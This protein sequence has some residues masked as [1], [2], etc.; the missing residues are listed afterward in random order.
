MVYNRGQRA[1]F[2]NWAQRGNRGWGYVD[3]LPYFKRS[4]RRIG[5]DDDAVPWP[6]GRIPVTDMDWIHPVSEAFIAGAAGMGIPRNPD[7][8]GASQAGR[9]LFPAR[10][11]QRLAARRGAHV[12]A[13]R[14]PSRQ[15]GSAHRCACRGDPAG[16]QARDRRALHP[17]SRPHQPCGAGAARG[18]RQRRHRQ[19]RQAAADLRHRARR[20]CCSPSARRCCTS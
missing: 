14:A 10:H 18:D 17:R 7:Y 9:R 2:D 3:I 4:E 1:D 20:R 19:H 12:P 8:N 11:P 15:S 16:R 5:G 13:S 6:R